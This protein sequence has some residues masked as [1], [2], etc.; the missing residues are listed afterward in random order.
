M[1]ATTAAGQQW[2]RWRRRARTK[3]LAQGAGCRSRGAAI[4]G[5]G[6]NGHPGHHFFLETPRDG[7][8]VVCKALAGVEGGESMATDT[9]RVLGFAA[10]H[11]DESDA[12]EVT[13]EGDRFA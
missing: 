1:A 12:P 10:G 7:F 5:L 11:V 8:S 4:A 3:R 9:I 13:I 2:R 6:R